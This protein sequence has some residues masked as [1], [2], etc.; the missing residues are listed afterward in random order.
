M[1]TPGGPPQQ[2]DVPPQQ[3][4]QQQPY[5]QQPYEAPGQY[6]AQGYPPPYASG[7]PRKSGLRRAGG[8]MFFIGLALLILG[9][10]GLVLG[11]GR[12]VGSFDPADFDSPTV[13]VAGSTPVDLTAGATRSLSASSTSADVAATCTV[14]GPNGS[15]QVVSSEV[16]GETIPNLANFTAV[17]SGEHVIECSQP[18]VVL[19]PAIDPG[20][21]AGAGMILVGALLLGGLGFLLALVGAIMWLVGRSRDNSAALR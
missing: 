6:P 8:W 10:I 20:D 21:I 17:D 18:G 7:P 4:Y 3:P 12:A 1:T 11:F 15:V 13:E 16:F 2:P 19:G 14:T 5:Q 9:I